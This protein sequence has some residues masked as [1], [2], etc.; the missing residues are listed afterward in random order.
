MQLQKKEE[1]FQEGSF[2]LSGFI[3]RIISAVKKTQAKRVAVDSISAIYP[4][5]KDKNTIRQE[6]HRLFL[7]LTDLG[8]TTLLTA[9]RT[10][11]G[12]ESELQV[13]MEEFVSDNVI[14]LHYY[15]DKLRADRI[16]SIEILKFRGTTHETLSCPVLISNEGMEVYPRPKARF[17]FQESSVI[18]IKVGIP[19]LDNMLFGGIYMNSCTLITGASGSGKSVFTLHF[20]KE[21]IK[22]KEKALYIG[23]EESREQIFRNAQSIGWDLKSEVEEGHVIV[24]CEVPDALKPEEH[25]KNIINLITKHKIKRFVLD[26]IS[27]F[28]R[29][30]S[31]DRFREFTGGLVAYLKEKRVTAV[32]TNTSSTLLDVAKTTETH[33]SSTVDNIVLLKFIEL[34]GQLQRAVTIIK[35]RG[36]DHDKRVRELIITSNG[37]RILDPF[38]GVENLMGGSARRV[39]MPSEEIIE[40]TEKAEMLRHEY[41]EGNIQSDVYEEKIERLRENLKAIRKSMIDF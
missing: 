9:E 35:S 10:T 22:Q 24:D 41:I 19:G 37:M 11:D 32:L 25:Y 30:V 18:K 38:Y 39:I 12:G 29:I 1:S 2:D 40:Y 15:L 5:F 17:Q 36:T 13:G 3:Y 26:S 8:V 7:S 23:F 33:L 6:L 28:E 20:I 16:R 31:Q 4:R 34:D 14:L 21:G 27:A